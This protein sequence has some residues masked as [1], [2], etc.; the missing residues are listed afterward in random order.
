MLLFWVWWLVSKVILIA[1]GLMQVINA[2]KYFSVKT[3]HKSYLLLPYGSNEEPVK[4]KV[5]FFKVENKLNTIV[6]LKPYAHT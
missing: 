3:S 6:K 4:D 1:R 5:V 2:K